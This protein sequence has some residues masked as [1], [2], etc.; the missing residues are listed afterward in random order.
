MKQGRANSNVSSSKNEPK[1]KGVNPAHPARMGVMQGNH[2]T[3]MRGTIGVQRVDVYRGRGL[4][5]PMAGKKSH[6]KGSQG[7]H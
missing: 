7:R 4:E 6:P 2:A 1:S 3:D 5:A